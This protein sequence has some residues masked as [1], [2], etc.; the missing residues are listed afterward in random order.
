MGAEFQTRL[1]AKVFESGLTLALMSGERGRPWSGL[2]DLESVQRF[3]SSPVL[4]AIFDMPW[5][6][7]FIAA[8][9][10]FHPWLGWFALGGLVLLQN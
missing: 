8:I 2:R 5:T 6:P 9:F 7:V 1:D 3:M 4:F 10:M